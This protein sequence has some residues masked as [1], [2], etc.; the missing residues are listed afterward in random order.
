MFEKLFDTLIPFIG[1]IACIL[2]AN[3]EFR[4]YKDGKKPTIKM[5]D[6]NKGIEYAYFN[7]LVEAIQCNTIFYSDIIIGICKNF[8]EFNVTF[9]EEK[10]RITK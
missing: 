5:K 9:V 8:K 3:R 10:L 7:L 1:G 2:C 6:D 4:K